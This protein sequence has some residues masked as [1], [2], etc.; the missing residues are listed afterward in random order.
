MPKP[1]LGEVADS[2]V[3]PLFSD[4]YL[5]EIGSVPGAAGN[6]RPLTL[7]CRTAIKPGFTIENVEVALFGH[8]LQYAGR[9]TFSH[10]MQVE[11]VENGK[12]EIHTTMEEW[13]EKCRG[14]QSQH[15]SYK[16]EYSKTAT[17][18]MFDTTGKVVLRYRIYGLWPSSVPDTNLDG[19]SATLITLGIGFKYDYYERDNGQGSTNSSPLARRSF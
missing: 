18:T 7:Q 3:D 9:K 5:L 19:Q 1:T 16:N 15:G 11:Y 4:N 13:G 6:S 12:G 10:D 2:I 14:T 8:T 17:L